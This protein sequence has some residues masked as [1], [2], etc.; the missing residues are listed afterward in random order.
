MLTQSSGKQLR[1]VIQEHHASHLHYDFRLEMLEE[2]D[3]E[4]YILKSWAV[5]KNI[6]DGIGIKRLAIQVEDHDMNYIDFEGIIEEGNYG[7]GEVI[8]WD[9]GSYELIS[10]KYNDLGELKEIIVM[11]NGK[12]IKGEFALIKTRGF[13][14]EKNKEKN[15]LIFRKK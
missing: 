11:L 3:S 10:K 2:G 7:A 15:W 12:K 9:N 8:I 5:P 14:S 6:S 13:G 1:F 4:N